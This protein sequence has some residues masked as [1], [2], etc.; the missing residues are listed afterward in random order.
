MKTLSFIRSRVNSFVAD[1]RRSVAAL[2]AATLLCVVFAVP[3]YSQIGFSTI[4]SSYSQNFDDMGT[5]NVFLTDEITGSLLGFFALREFGNTNPNF[6][7]ADDGSDTS[8]GF[9]NYGGAL[10]FERALGMLPG[11]GTGGMRIGVRFVND[12]LV[13]VNSIQVTYTGEQ[14]RNGGNQSPHTLVFSYRKDTVVN[15][16]VTG[17]YTVV[18]ALSFTTPQVGPI[19]GG[20]DGNDAAN[21]ATL[22]ANFAVTIMPGEEI[23][24]RW[25]SL[26]AFGDD[27]GIAI[28]DLQV[29]PYGAA[30]AA[31][32][33]IGG[34][35]TDSFGRGIPKTRVM[36]SGGNMAE[37]AFAMTN[38]FGYYSF[39]NVQAGQ[40]YFVR[41]ESKR[42]RFDNPVL[43]INLG[44]SF[45]NADFVANP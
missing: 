44:D 13:P 21:R 25:E 17:F 12:T 34:R 23:M 4:G 43:F 9:K 30:T 1:P 2:V 45:T 5:G 27:H 15:D 22:T 41:V 11:P 35:V 26:D 36:L 10:H 24:L 7:G 28:D 39:D 38:A 32:A 42:H 14:W 3:A 33:T 6:V 19:A 8:V 31:D 29:T 20:L 37:P 40:S 16:L 18:P